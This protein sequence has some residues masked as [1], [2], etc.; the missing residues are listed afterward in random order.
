MF[1]LLAALFFL[2]GASA[3]VYQ[4]LWLR[5]LGLVFG[6]TVHAASTVWAAFMA[7]LALGT[8]AAGLAGDRVRRPIVWF[9]VAELLTGVTAML[10]PAAIDA[11]QG[12]YVNL[13]PSLRQSEAAAVAVRFVMAFGVLIVPTALMGST[14]PLLVRSSAFTGSRLGSRAGALYAANTAGAIAGTLVA[15]LFLIPSY[16]IRTSFVVAAG[17]NVLVGV[18]AFLVATTRAART[19]GGAAAPPV[20]SGAENVP[21]AEDLAQRRVVL[22][23]FAVSGFFSLAL[24]VVWFRVLTL[25]LRPT[26]YGYAFMLA[27]LLFG[28]A[29]GSGLATPLM[30]R[31][32]PSLLWLAILEAGIAV[33]ALL[34]FTTLGSIPMSVAAVE[35]ALRPIMGPYLTYQAVVSFIV[36]FPTALLLGLAF[37]IGL[38]VWLGDPTASAVRVARRTGVSTA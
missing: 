31:R 19:F 27:T 32:F 20:A 23:V 14:M 34:S 8:V 7:G 1:P 26:V 33:A 30:K 9:G 10:T 25:F 37:P 18:A 22:A 35:S 12:V 6:V 24:E 38:S 17:V 36:I 28:I 15:G 3:L 4:V 13:A 5:L 21:A 11:L 16:G 2:S 29:L